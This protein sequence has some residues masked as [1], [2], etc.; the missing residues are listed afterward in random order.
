M[1]LSACLL[2]NPRYLLLDEPTAGIDPKERRDF[3]G[4]IHDL[5]GRGVSVLVCTHYMDE[6]ERCQR[7]AYILQGR[8]LADGPPGT[9][10][11]VASGDLADHGP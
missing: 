9:A 2:H 1:A 7:L 3:W 4:H 5:A 10:R 8:L 11:G 6:A